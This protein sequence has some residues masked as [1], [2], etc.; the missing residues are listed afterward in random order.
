MNK[1]EAREFLLRIVTALGT[2][3]IEYYSTEDGDKAI[4]AINILYYGEEDG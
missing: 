1:E 2:V 3:G 4:K